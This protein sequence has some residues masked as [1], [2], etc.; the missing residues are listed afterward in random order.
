[1]EHAFLVRT[2]HQLGMVREERY[3]RLTRQLSRRRRE[4]LDPAAD[5]YADTEIAA[6]ALLEASRSV[7]DAPD[8]RR[9]WPWRWELPHPTPPFLTRG[10]YVYEL[11]YGLVEARWWMRV[12][13]VLVYRRIVDHIAGLVLGAVTSI[14]IVNDYV[15][16]ALATGGLRGGWNLAAVLALAICWLLVKS[17]AQRSWRGTLGNSAASVVVAGLVSLVFDP[18]D[19]VVPTLVSLIALRWLVIDAVAFT[20]DSTGLLN[21]LLP[22]R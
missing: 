22:R 14:G 10:P 7:D 21:K 17:A 3:E 11:L 13:D 6:I 2:A 12:I 20:A 16:D 19:P 9:A 4:F 5:M 18:H 8:G 15:V 1:M